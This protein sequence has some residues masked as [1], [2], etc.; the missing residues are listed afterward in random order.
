MKK[1]LLTCFMLVFVL[2]A[3]A[4]DRTVSG[5]VTDAETGEALPGVNVLLKGT[6]TGITTDLDGNYKISVPSEGG[7]LVFTFIGMETQEVTIGSRSV[8]DV[9]MQT[10]VEQLSEVV[11]VGYGTTLKTE[12]TGAISSVDSEQL[13]RVPVVAPDQAL[14]GLASGVFVSG[15][16]GTPGSGMN[17]RVRGQ[18]SINAG[19]SP[20]YVVDGVVIQSG[21][22]A[23]IGV[24]G[25]SQ[26][27]LNNINPQDIESIQVLKDASQ[28]AIY[29]A[30]AAN[31]VVLITTK[32]GKAGKAQIDFRA[33]S[34]VGQP[35]QVLEKASAAEQVELEREA[36]L[37][38]N[39]GA[40]PPTD[41][42]LGWDGTTD[43]D[44]IDEVFRDARIS[45]YNLSASGGSEDFKY[46]IS[47]GYRDEEGVT[48]GSEFQR[49]SFRTNVDYKASEKLKIQSSVNLTRGVTQRL[50]GDNNI[51]GIYSAAILTPS[52]RPIRDPETGELVDALPS[53]N[54]NPL[55]AAL[56]SRNEVTNNRIVANTNFTYN[57][58]EGLD[59]TT[60]FSYDYIYFKEDSY[61]PVSTAQGRG[62]NGTGTYAQRD[63]GTWIVEPTLR[64]SNI[65]GTGHKVTG[66]L[67]GTLQELTRF[68]DF[69]TGTGFA[70]E[71]LTYLISAAIPS[72]LSS[73]TDT[74][75][76]N[77]IFGRANYAYDERY[78]AS[79]SVRRDGSSR[80]GPDRR[81]GLFY[82]VSGGWNFSEEDWFN[83]GVISFGKIRASYGVTGNDQIGNFTY[84]GSFT[85]GA[86]YLDRP[87]SAPDQ[88]ENP[89]LQ[90]E[91]TQSI[92]IGLEL[93][94]FRNRVNL[95]TG[96]FQQNTTALLFADP[97]PWTTGFGSIQSNLGEVMNRGL[98]FDL[99]T[100]NVDAGDFRWN[101]NLN[102]SFLENEVVKINSEEPILSG[103]ASAIIQGQP[104]NTFYGVKWLGVDPATG[105]SQFE[106]LNGDG[107]IGGDD[108]QI[109]GDHQPDFLGGITNSFSYKGFTLDA[110]FQFVYGVDV[111]N[112]TLGFSQNVSGPW[113][114]DKAVYERRW[115]QPGDITD[116]P[117]AS[118]TSSI[119]FTQDNSRFLSDGSY[120]RL[121]NITFAYNLPS[122]W[123]EKI[124][125]RSLR[126][127]A[128]GQNLLTFTNYNGADPEVSAFGLS[129]TALGTDFLTIPQ[130]KMISGGINIGL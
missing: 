95:N 103:F 57:I 110:F 116:I 61:R 69:A 20:L 112:N 22:L 114:L 80:F 17:I 83:V 96:V 105:E 113:G 97:V 35:T 66:V 19:N 106:D 42:E 101:T 39:P 72:D 10:D 14:Q 13:S 109:L 23:Q 2:H 119:D 87:A 29:G 8:I 67:G 26:N 30:R 94:L 89:N 111:Y 38:D 25:D 31:G 99:S 93:A 46:Y 55:R 70:R 118:Q 34:G 82:A 40:I 4:Q 37:N 28:T 3:W 43:T 51:Y 92:D 64:Y 44:W 65:F 102:L 100:V 27:A 5:T 90:W 9:Q 88:L 18:T 16:N 126:V 68:T 60:D 117:K 86:N 123:L 91:E 58:I 1:I 41:A 129:N 11:V 74:Y 59:F 45:E 75:S 6:G 48:I 52:T 115:Q 21:N 56:L 108:N 85:G 32:R 127:F 120:L 130:I 24:G 36:F 107:I 128:Q 98:E 124:N 77:S 7:A 73:Y 49:Y 53:F 63:Q 71:D 54:T 122:E 79:L 121:K 47:G 104:L 50:N 125:I 12:L 84:I 62:T 15:T 78:L 81:F 76:F 33:W